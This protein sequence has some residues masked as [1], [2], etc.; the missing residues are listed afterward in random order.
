MHISWNKDKEK[1][2][3]ENRKISLERISEKLKNG[4]FDVCPVDNQVNHKGQQM[5]LVEIDEYIHCVPFVEDNT[6]VFLKT[7]FKS[8]K[9]QKEKVWKN[10]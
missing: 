7:A 1:W 3:W 10:H 6:G 4:E 2:L 8:R 9:L 5:F